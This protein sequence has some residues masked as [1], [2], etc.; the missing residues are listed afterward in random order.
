[1]RAMAQEPTLP[2]LS[3][4][5]TD[6]CT[7]APGFWV[8]SKCRKGE[9][10]TDEHLI[11]T[12]HEDINT[13][14]HTHTIKLVMMVIHRDEFQYLYWWMMMTVVVTIVVMVVCEFNAYFTSEKKFKQGPPVT[15]RIIWTQMYMQYIYIPFFKFKLWHNISPKTHIGQKIPLFAR[16]H[17]SFCAGGGHPFIQILLHVHSLN[18]NTYNCWKMSFLWGPAS[19]Q[20]LRLMEEIPNNHLGCI[21]PCKWW[22][23]LPYQLVQDFYMHQPYVSFWE[24]NMLFL[25]S[26]LSFACDLDAISQGR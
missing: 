12:F 7:S 21:K 16:V 24:C 23:K 15:N 1:M 17:L 19:C 8:M 11:Y 20:V 6:N 14:T 18:L 9:S 5:C 2:Q 4:C 3:M 22:E 10:K 25:L 13:H 26:T